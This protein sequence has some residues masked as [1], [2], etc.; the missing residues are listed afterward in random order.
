MDYIAFFVGVLVGWMI[1][2][3]SGR[4]VGWNEKKGLD[5]VISGLEPG[6]SL[7]INK[8]NQIE[9]EDDSPSTWD[10][11]KGNQEN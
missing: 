3:L 9:V 7:Y 1:G 6:Q 10:L 2:S 4:L 8:G 11:L 5:E